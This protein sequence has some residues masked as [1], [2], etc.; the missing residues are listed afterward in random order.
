MIGID[1]TKISRFDP[2][3]LHFY[4]E[5]FKTNYLSI[6]DVAKFWVCF[7][8]L[9]KAEGKYFN[10]KDVKISFSPNQAPEIKDTNGVLS[11]DYVLSLS[12]E[13]DLIIAIAMRK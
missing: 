9:V 4:N 6:K 8:S 7:E 2:A 13:E 10:H 1:I 11:G 5:K 3:K 12:H